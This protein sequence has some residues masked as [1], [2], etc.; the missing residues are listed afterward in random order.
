MKKKLTNFEPV[1][2]IC[3][4]ESDEFHVLHLEGHFRNSE[5]RNVRHGNTREFVN[6]LNRTTVSRKCVIQTH[7]IVRIL[8]IIVRRTWQLAFSFH[9]SCFHPLV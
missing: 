6:C 5:Q 8:R 7:L 9:F 4:D 3:D 1:P 2:R